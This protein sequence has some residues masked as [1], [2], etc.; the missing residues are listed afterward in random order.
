[1]HIG[2]G[3]SSSVY[4]ADNPLDN[5]L[6]ALV[7]PLTIIGHIMGLDLT[8]CTLCYLQAFFL[9]TAKQA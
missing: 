9:E 3:A 1:M 8:Y 5:P 2:R 7:T 6:P 4:G